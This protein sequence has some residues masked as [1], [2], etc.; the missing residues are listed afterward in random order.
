MPLST[1]LGLNGTSPDFANAD[2]ML[3]LGERYTA[4]VVVQQR[5]VLLPHRTGTA[6]VEIF[7]LVTIR[8]LE[9]AEHANVARLELVRSMGWQTAENDIIRQ[10]E[11]KHLHRLVRRETIIDENTRLPIGSSTGGRIKHFLQPVE[12][13]LAVG[14]P[15]LRHG[16]VPTR[17][18][19]C[20]PVTTMCG[21]RPDD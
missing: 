4:C 8:G 6:V 2:L 21:G 18:R 1:L 19:M 13:D 9:R 5:E 14:I 12:A 7:D 15:R 20:D 17:G 10:A 16:K 3:R 11:L